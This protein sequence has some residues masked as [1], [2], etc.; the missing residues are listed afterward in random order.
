MKYLVIVT[1]PSIRLSAAI[2]EIHENKRKIE[3]E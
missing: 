2:K 3:N 1:N